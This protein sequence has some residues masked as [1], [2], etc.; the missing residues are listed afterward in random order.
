VVGISIRLDENILHI[1]DIV[2]PVLIS[3]CNHT[4][5][6]RTGLQLDLRGKISLFCPNYSYLVYIIDN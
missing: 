3:R 4:R 5:I 1:Q 6:L 2:E